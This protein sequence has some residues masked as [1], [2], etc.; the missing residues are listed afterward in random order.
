MNNK[1]RLEELITSADIS[2]FGSDK[3]FATAYAEALAKNNT[4]SFPVKPG[5]TVFYVD[6]YKDQTVVMAKV[7]DCIWA[8]G[9]KIFVR[10]QPYESYMYE[11]GVN[12][13]ATYKEAKAVA[14]FKDE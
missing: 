6:G 11:W 7:K 4:V 1:E 3:P 5:D 12:C 14:D 2:L 8:G 9:D 10:C 13:F